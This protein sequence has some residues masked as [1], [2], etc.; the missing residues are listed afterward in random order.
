MDKANILVVDDQDSIR[1]FVGK[2]LEDDGYTV[3]TWSDTADPAYLVHETFL[4]SVWARGYDNR[5]NPLWNEMAV[6][7]GGRVDLLHLPLEGSEGIVV[8]TDS[9]PAGE[10]HGVRLLLACEPAQYRGDAAVNWRVVPLAM[11]GVGGVTAI[12]TRLAAVTVSC[13]PSLAGAPTTRPEK[14]ESLSFSTPM[15]ITVS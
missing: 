12:D 9:I 13:V 2:A 7:S 14:P 10:Y 1:H 5:A 3:V 4:S 15:A 8:A 11:D 6:V